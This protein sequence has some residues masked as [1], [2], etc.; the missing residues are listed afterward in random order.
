MDVTYSSTGRGTVFTDE[1]NIKAVDQY[2]A[3]SRPIGRAEPISGRR[4]DKVFISSGEILTPS[5]VTTGHRHN[6]ANVGLV[7]LGNHPVGTDT[8]TFIGGQNA[9]FLGGTMIAGA[10]SN[11]FGI[12]VTCDSYSFGTGTLA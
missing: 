4:Y 7:A 5:S 3:L 9:V 10:D 11:E 6:R 2:L 1:V 12:K 8:N